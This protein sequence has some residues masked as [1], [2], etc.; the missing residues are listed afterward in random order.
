LR[1]FFY[2][3]TRDST[4]SLVYDIV[5]LNVLHT[6][7]LMFQLS[8]YSR[9]RKGL[10]SNLMSVP[11]QT[12]VTYSKNGTKLP[13]IICLRLL[14]AVKK[15]PKWSNSESGLVGVALTKSLHSIRLHNF[16]IPGSPKCIRPGRPVCSLQRACPSRNAPE[17]CE[18]YN[19]VMISVFLIHGELSE[20]FRTL[21]G[22]HR[23]CP[24][25][26]LLFG[27][28]I[29]GIMV[30]TLKGRQNYGAPITSDET[31]SI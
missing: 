15:W 25:T 13:T 6:G 29:D 11:F 7:R 16:S 26:P 24:L 28:V 10:V 21:S 2:E 20:S 19:F 18:Y 5:Q 30:Q 3:V 17:V 9:H 1:K 14:V 8:R 22:V 27:A 23:K 12:M 4:E 31:L